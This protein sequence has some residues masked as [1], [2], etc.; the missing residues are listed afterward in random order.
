MPDEP[1]CVTSQTILAQFQAQAAAIL[2]E[3][4]VLSSFQ[5]S[6]I[7]GIEREQPI[8]RFL[9]KHL[10]NR[11]LVGQGSIASADEILKNQH[12]IIM[13]DRDASFTLLN[14]VDAQL[15]PIEAVHLIVEVRSVF[16]DLDSV[17]KSLRAVRKLRTSQGLRQLGKQGSELGITAKPVQTLV[18]YEG[19]TPETAIGHLEKFNAV[20][21]SD[22]ARMTIDS[23]L[24]LARQGQNS[25][26]GGY[27][28]GYQRTEGDHVFSHHYY[29][30]TGEAGLSGPM[31]IKDGLNSFAHWYAGILNHLGGATA[32][33]ANLYSYLGETLTYLPWKN[34]PC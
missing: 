19:P 8:R 14:T 33:P 26:N 1:R 20:D 12:D 24:V 6:G 17:A 30:S 22:G 11:Y 16:G 13:A 7:K 32:Y 5:H 25:A 27:L 15:V 10:P 34:K 9:A 31:V 28:I 23:I 2:A 3:G 21:A 4:M 29:P 18:V